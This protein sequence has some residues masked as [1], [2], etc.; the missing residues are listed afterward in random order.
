LKKPKLNVKVLA[1]DA[2]EKTIHENGI[3]GMNARHIAKN[4]GCAVG[5]LYNHF[6]SID[7]LIL[8]VN[9]RTLAK[10]ETALQQSTL[11]AS[12]GNQGIQAIVDAYMKFALEH[13]H[14]WQTLFEHHM[15]KHAEIPQ[16]YF[17]QRQQLFQHIEAQLKSSHPTMNDMQSKLESRAL[18]AGIQGVC[19]LAIN[20]KLNDDHIPFQK[21]ATTL[22]QHFLAKEGV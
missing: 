18:W 3:L 5:T 22:V 4:I 21:I 8:A 16:A 11:Q 14:A 6:S 17:Q 10:L 9:L 12:N 2:A 13:T 20:K 7:E 19:V 15:P 1:I